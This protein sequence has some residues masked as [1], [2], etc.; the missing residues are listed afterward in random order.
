MWRKESEKRSAREVGARIVW[1]LWTLNST[2]KQV[3]R[4]V[5]KQIAFF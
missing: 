5:I 1:A 3:Y 4:F 2:E